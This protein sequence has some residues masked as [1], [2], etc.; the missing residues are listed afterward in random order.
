MCV[1]VSYVLVCNFDV[2]LLGL[3]IGLIGP[4]CLPY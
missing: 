3:L 1:H 4:D 2:L